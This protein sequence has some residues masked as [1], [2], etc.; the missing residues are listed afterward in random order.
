VRLCF[1]PL[2]RM[3]HIG[4]EFSRAEIALFSCKML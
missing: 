3:R 2:L 1:P 4:P